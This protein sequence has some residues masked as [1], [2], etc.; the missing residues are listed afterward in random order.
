V[1]HAGWRVI[2]AKELGDHLLS[3][4]FIV[5][6][7]VLGLARAIPLY[8]AADLIRAAAPRRARPGR[9]PR[10]VHDRVAGLLVPA[11]RLVRRHRG[12]L[13]G[14]AFAFDAINGERSEGT[15]P[16]SWPSRSTATT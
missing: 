8:F 14:L 5:L 2:A 11:R 4:R 7:I 12:P 1:P 3:V 13:L 9:L 10:A 16:R 15:L 6:L